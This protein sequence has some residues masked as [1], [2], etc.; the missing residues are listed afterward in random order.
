MIRVLYIE[1]DA[2]KRFSQSR[3]M[4]FLHRKLKSVL[5]TVNTGEAA[6]R[7]LEALDNDFDVVLCDWNFVKGG[8]TGGD[9]LEWIKVHRP[10]FATKF[11]F[12]SNDIAAKEVAN[13]NQVPYLAQPVD[14]DRLADVIKSVTG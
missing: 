13:E 10:R 14:M 11:I 9:V 7:I 2:D 3:V 1:S 5:T 12:L 6:I 4:K 8:I